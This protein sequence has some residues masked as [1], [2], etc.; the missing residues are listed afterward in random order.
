MEKNS[1]SYSLKSSLF[2][3][4][5]NEETIKLKVL[6]GKDYIE[7]QILP[8]DE[9]IGKIIIAGCTFT[10]CRSDYGAGLLVEQNCIVVLHGST[11]SKCDAN[12]NGGGAYICVKR[13]EPT[14]KDNKYTEIRDDK[15]DQIDVN[16]CCFDRC[17]AK[18]DD[19]DL[20]KGFGGSAMIA[21]KKVNHI[22]SSSNN[23]LDSGEQSN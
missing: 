5:E 20:K 14:V 10:N 21:G 7:H 19:N 3:T 15:S 1:F 6:R 23:H 13:N 4:E 9:S 22:F 2:F 8:N 18:K 17:T 12:I 16:Y 11:F